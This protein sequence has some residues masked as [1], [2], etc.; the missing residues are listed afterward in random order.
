MKLLKFAAGLLCAGALFVLPSKALASSV[1]LGGGLLGPTGLPTVFVGTGSGTSFNATV[2]SNIYTA[3]LS[4]ASYTTYAG[5]LG[6]VPAGDF[7]YAYIIN[8][9]S[10]VPAD[11]F[12]AHF[13]VKS[14]TIIDKIGFD[15]TAGGV[16][17]TTVSMDGTAPDS[18]QFNFTTGGHIT[19]GTSS[20]VLLFATSGTP[21][22]QNGTLADGA[23]DTELVVSAFS[24][25]T[26]GTPL[27]PLPTTACAGMA[28]LGL[29]SMGRRRKAKTA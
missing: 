4:G 16:K 23:S 9:I 13:S 26:P 6:G 8:D 11:D 3:A 15:T 5:F 29:A 10:Q 14:G 24:P 20:T 17:P 12:L 2:Q 18:A 28:L 1:F 19:P 27:T 22:L 25:G 21:V 7:I